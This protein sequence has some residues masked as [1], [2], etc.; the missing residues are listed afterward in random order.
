MYVPAVK[1]EADTCIPISRSLDV[2]HAWSHRASPFIHLP[3]H[4]P[5]CIHPAPYVEYMIR[6]V[7]SRLAAEAAMVPG[8]TERLHLPY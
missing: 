2:D 1:K 3:G 4:Q 7:I 5:S 6:P 8:A